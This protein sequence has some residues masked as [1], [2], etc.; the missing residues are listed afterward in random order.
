[1]ELIVSDNCGSEHNISIYSGK[2]KRWWLVKKWECI[3]PESILILGKHFQRTSQ[4]LTRGANQLKATKEV[5]KIHFNNQ[6][7]RKRNERQKMISSQLCGQELHVQTLLVNISGKAFFY[8]TKKWM[9]MASERSKCWHFCNLKSRA[10]PSIPYLWSCDW[11]T[12]N[13][14]KLFEKKNRTRTL[15][16]ENW[17]SPSHFSGPKKG[18]ATREGDG[19]AC[20]WCFRSRQCVQCL[21]D[22]IGCSSLRERWVN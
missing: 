1:M 11:P 15:P 6:L 4:M 3:L 10:N 19:N 5:Q 17:T 7:V 16:A 18:T 12:S 22:R 14:V 13:L 2:K 8:L 20:T 21:K 9:L